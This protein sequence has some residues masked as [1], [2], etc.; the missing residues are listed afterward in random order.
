MS[1]LI[2]VLLYTIVLLAYYIIDDYPILFIYLAWI[3]GYSQN[4]IS[5]Y[6]DK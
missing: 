6:V 2:S 5:K 4:I 3:T 1:N